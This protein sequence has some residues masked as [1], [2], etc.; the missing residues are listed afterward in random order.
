MIVRGE[1]KNGGGGM[2]VDMVVAKR[3][4]SAPGPLGEGYDICDRRHI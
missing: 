2:G 3:K 1:E 4:A